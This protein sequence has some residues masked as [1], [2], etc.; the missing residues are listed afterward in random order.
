MCLC[1]SCIWLLH[2][3]R[4]SAQD[5]LNPLQLALVVFYLHMPTI[6]HL[7][8]STNKIQAHTLHN[9]DWIKLL[10][11]LGCMQTHAV[12]MQYIHQQELSI[13]EYS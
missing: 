8:M 10:M 5:D 11:V 13:C 7:L 2:P 12:A 3:A 4:T 1:A 6:V 9:Y